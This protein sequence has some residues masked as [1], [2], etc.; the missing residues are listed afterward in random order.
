MF[1]Q[2]DWTTETTGDPFLLNAKNSTEENDAP[3]SAINVEKKATLPEIAKQKLLEEL[4]H[5]S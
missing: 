4:N 3:S 5:V 2:R 1:L